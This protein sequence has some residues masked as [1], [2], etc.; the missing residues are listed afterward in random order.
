VD[1]RLDPVVL[2]SLERE[3]ADRYQSA[4]EVKEDVTGLHR[5][6]H[7]AAPRAEAPRFRPISAS[8]GC[9]VILVAGATL[10][11]IVVV[12]LAGVRKSS[13]PKVVAPPRPVP[14]PE[15]V[16]PP[17]RGEGVPRRSHHVTHAF[18]VDEFWPAAELPPGLE[19]SK[20]V[21]G[22]DLLKMA[23][24]S[25]AILADLEYSRGLDFQ[26]GK[27]LMVGLQFKSEF[28]RRRWHNEPAWR[29][30]L[31]HWHYWLGGD[32]QGVI[33]IRHDGSPA[34][35]AAKDVLENYVE[36]YLADLYPPKKK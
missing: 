1:Q 23:G 20:S 3:P 7:V 33:L 32:S 27:A 11:L 29:R 9:L 24:L 31:E 10:L 35:M 25:P 19:G 18:K 30:E 17:E 13:P 28:A 16:R 34:G 12:A 36:K 14:V 26:N 4:G 6:P 2:K 5:R 8:G 15:V 21:E 22:A